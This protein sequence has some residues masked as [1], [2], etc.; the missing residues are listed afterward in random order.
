MG[1]GAVL[2]YTQYRDQYTALSEPMPCSFNQIGA[3]TTGTAS[4]SSACVSTMFVG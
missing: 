2:P 1:D 3:M 4:A